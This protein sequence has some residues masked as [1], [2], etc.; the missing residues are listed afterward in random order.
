MNQVLLSANAIPLTR[1]SQL[2]VSIRNITG[3]AQTYVV[4]VKTIDET[5][6]LI[7]A[8][9]EL[10]LGTSSLPN[11]Q[12]YPLTN[13]FLISAQVKALNPLLIRTG[14]YVTLELQSGSPTTTD[15]TNILPLTSGYVD[16]TKPLG[17]PLSQPESSL[18]G[19]G[20]VV[21]LSTANPAAGA[22]IAAPV[23]VNQLYQP[24]GAGFVLTT[25][26]VAATRTVNIRYDVNSATVAL[27]PSRTN[28][29]TFTTVTYLL[30][31][32][33][34]LPT[35]TTTR[36]YIPIPDAFKGVAAIWNTV[37]TNIQAGDQFSAIST[38][39]ERWQIPTA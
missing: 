16:Y 36:I 8:A 37:T 27:I 32:G 12:L 7:N 4:L 6:K 14:V 30:W 29:G 5:G 10:S 23:A 1:N 21:N 25:S 15:N 20:D 26:A 19:L 11:V 34:N 35:D 18:S 28:Q 2:R 39:I 38:Q 13:G 31:R 3:A 17:Y 33:P 22:E 9:Y 24:L